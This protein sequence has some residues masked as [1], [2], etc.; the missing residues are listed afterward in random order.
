MLTLIVYLFILGSIVDRLQREGL[1]QASL[2]SPFYPRLD[3]LA[4]P[5]PRISRRIH[6]CQNLT[7]LAVLGADSCPGFVPRLGVQWG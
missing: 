1:W 3:F 2:C 6:D 7:Q 4:E 5:P